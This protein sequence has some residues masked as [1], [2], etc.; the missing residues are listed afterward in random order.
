MRR[1]RIEKWV[2]L[3][4][5]VFISVLGLAGCGGGGGGGGGA[6]ASPITRAGGAQGNGNSDLGYDLSQTGQYVAFS[7]R[8]SDLLGAGVDTNNTYDIF[9]YDKTAGTTS[10]VSVGNGVPPEQGNN[11]SYYP[12]ISGDGRYVAFES[13]AENLVG[14]TDTNLNS[15]IFVRDRTLSVTERVS[16][17]QAGLPAQ[18]N[19][20]SF[21]PS[22]SANGRYVAF[23]SFATNLGIAADING[24]SDVFVFDR[25]LLVTQ[26]VSVGPGGVE[27]DNAS[28]T[29]GH[30][31]SDDGQV[32]AFESTA[33]NLV[34]GDTNGARDVFVHDRGTGITTRV[35]VDS[36]G[37]EANG[38]SHVSSIS[39]D[40]RYVVFESDATNLVASDNNGVTDIFV[41]DLTAGT[42]TRVSVSSTGEQ[43][44]G[45]SFALGQRAISDDGQ[46]IVFESDATNLVSGDTNAVSDVFVRNLLNN[47]TTRLSITSGSAQPTT[48]STE[49]AISRDGATAAFGSFGLEFMADNPTGYYN[50]YI[51]SVP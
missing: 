9:V 34:V 32:I 29:F 26:R 10:R 14:T 38:A 45:A 36:A 33:T 6:A 37:A 49:G 31:V 2:W 47:T 7:S 39:G 5:A 46:L 28:V 20:D 12:S 35:S 8:A 1:E 3:P 13:A 40:G 18:P 51:R 23:Y 44:N 17:A 22:I 41:R 27:A 42:T 30:A 11:G 43:A 19:G 50:V 21:K 25:T 48:F 15:D 4:V 16:V 24:V